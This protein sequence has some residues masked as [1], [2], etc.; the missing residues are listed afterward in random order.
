VSAT[1]GGE[2]GGGGFLFIFSFFSPPPTPLRRLMQ[3]FSKLVES[4]RSSWRRRRT[5]R[6]RRCDYDPSASV[7][8]FTV[9]RAVEEIRRASIVFGIVLVLGP[10]GRLW[11]TFAGWGFRRG[12]W[13]RLSGVSCSSALCRT[14]RSL[15]LPAMW[16]TVRA[17]VSEVHDSDWPTQR[18][19][20][21]CGF[22]VD[23]Y[24]LSY[25]ARHRPPVWAEG[26]VER[27]SAGELPRG[28]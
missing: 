25:P 10:V 21:V 28:G 14:F 5:G 26:A 2:W 6:G 19:C 15:R 13:V 9:A 8:E 27:V 7:D 12:L 17:P 11:V 3:D 1:A 4:W 23:N 16:S 18:R 22:R 24:R 20:R